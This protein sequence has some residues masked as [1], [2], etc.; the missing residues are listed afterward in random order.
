M[1]GKTDY[2][3]QKA[4]VP[5]T[6]TGCRDLC[7]PKGQLIP[8]YT[9]RKHC[10]KDQMA[11]IKGEGKCTHD[12][13][14]GVPFEKTQAFKKLRISTRS[15]ASM[16]QWFRR[17]QLMSSVMLSLFSSIPSV[18]YTIATAAMA[19]R[20]SFWECTSC[21]VNKYPQSGCEINERKR[22][23]RRVVEIPSHRKLPTARQSASNSDLYSWRNIQREEPDRKLS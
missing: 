15:V 4:K 5:C 8:T 11:D 21:I 12:A 20:A 2:S 19:E 13:T 18:T 7:G 9:H 6:C 23:I 22:T 3:Y 10:E 14:D 17:Y 1:S 16:V